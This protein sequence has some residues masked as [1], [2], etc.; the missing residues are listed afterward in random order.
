MTP[1]PEVGQRVKALRERAGLSRERLAESTGVSATLIKFVERGT[2]RLT[3]DTARKISDVLGVRDLGELY[4]PSV[5]L[6]LDGSSPTH[7]GVPDVRRAL[8]AWPVRVDGD[9]PTPDYL[10]GA[11]DAAWRTW[12]TSRQQRSEAGAILPGLIDTTQRATRLLD[13]TDRRRALASLAEVYHLA[14]AYL[15]WHGD[16]E[17]MWLT[18]D[19]GMQAS[20]DA[21]DP[22][23]I[24]RSI[25]YAAHLLRAVGRA[26]ES[27]ERLREGIDLVEPLVADG[28]AQAAAQLA[29]LHLC[30]AL[31]KA[32]TGDQGAWAEWDRARDVVHR[33][34]PADF[35]D[36]RTR[37]GRTLVD[38]YAVMCAVDLGDPEE[39]QR[40]AHA[41]DP[42]SIPST[43]RRARH[44]VELARSADL[45][46]SQEATLHLLQR[47]MSVSP[48]TVKYSPIARD[49]AG[50]L[51]TNSGAAIRADAVEL[52]R[53]VGA[54]AE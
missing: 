11:L 47:A 22:L 10:D 43:E 20:L 1:D 39:A 17:L 21:D 12:H 52:A 23:S 8:T 27:L 32:R 50:R 25:W 9:P 14:Q 44:Y 13:G 5:R 28:P 29:D 38:V 42:Q 30:A 40:R 35:V 33:T 49:I 53:A 7:P 41:L 2:R 4:G 45:E 31:T 34:L 19:R 51:V 24:G 48:E 37:V 6:T 15:A 16:R 18:V 3:L 36:A 26:E 46:G 54:P